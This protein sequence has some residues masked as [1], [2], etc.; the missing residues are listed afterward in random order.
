MSVDPHDPLDD[1]LDEFTERVARVLRAPERLGDDFERSL[2]TAIR[3]DRLVDQ[4]I[5]ITARR[6][7]SSRTWWS[8]PSWRLSPLGGLAAAATLVAITALGTLWVTSLETSAQVRLPT[9]AAVHDTVTYVR[10]VF[11]G[12]AHTVSVVGDFNAWGAT[13]TPL[14]SN[15]PGGAWAASVPMPSGR[16]EYA[17]IVDGKRWVADPFAPTNNDE[18][19]ANSSI[20]TVGD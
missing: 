10:F 8:A 4:S 3:E 1:P 11:V 12:R 5:S 19:G 14:E 17:F 9:I 13:P 6:P 2:V 7:A 16:H 20:I 18:F 15:G